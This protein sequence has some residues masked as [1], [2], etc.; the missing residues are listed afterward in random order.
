M[1]EIPM[2]SSVGG[3]AYQ[4]VTDWLN[5]YDNQVER[6]FK[7]FS[8]E[9]AYTGIMVFS[10]FE[11]M[12]RATHVLALKGIRHFV[13]DSKK[14]E[15]S[16]KYI[17]DAGQNFLFCASVMGGAALSLKDNLSKCSLTET[18]Q[19]INGDT[20]IDKVTMFYFQTFPKQLRA[21]GFPVP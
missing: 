9:I 19:I 12:A 21:M 5:K 15:F 4:H 8:A 2:S 7:Q 20:T 6:L 11:T 14:K 13:E 18:G 16:R 10:V 3:Y 1:R 17:V